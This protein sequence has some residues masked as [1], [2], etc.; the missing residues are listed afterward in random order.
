MRAV[1]WCWL[2]FAGVLIGC[3]QASAS[4]TIYSG[5]PNVAAGVAFFELHDPYTPDQAAG[6][7]FLVEYGSAKSSFG[8][9]DKVYLS[10]GFDLQKLA[11]NDMVPDAGGV[12]WA[13]RIWWQIWAPGA[14]TSGAPTWGRISDYED[15]WYNGDSATNSILEVQQKWP[16]YQGPVYYDTYFTG[17][18]DD[19]ADY[20]LW[21]I[22][23]G[24]QSGTWSYRVSV[25][26]P[27]ANMDPWITLLD[28]GTWTSP[29]TPDLIGNQPLTGSRSGVPEP[30]T[31]LLLA[32]GLAV[33]LV[34]RRQA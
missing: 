15:R 33:A 3:G 30:S 24:F 29:F 8:P 34:W 21:S 2:V 5:N 13:P 20:D 31:L 27:D 17:G 16:G 18:G 11:A 6:N 1:Q 10:I 9:S 23:G 14:S 12:K 4:L 26:V 19:P 32:S 28:D 7:P 25:E 22:G